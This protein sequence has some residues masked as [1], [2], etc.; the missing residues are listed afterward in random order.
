[1]AKASF[2]RIS[3]LF[4]GF[5]LLLATYSWIF[6]PDSG[7]LYNTRVRKTLGSDPKA[8]VD[9]SCEKPHHPLDPLTVQ[10]IKR[11]RTILSGHDPGFG[12]GSA[13]IHSMALDEPDKTRVVQWK[14]GNRL[15][16]RRAEVVAY[17]EAQT[18]VLTV[19]LDSGR[20][21][22]DV[23]NPTSGY[24][25]LTIDDVFAASQVPMIF[26]TNFLV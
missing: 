22:S 20:I 23:V 16:S 24:P 15:P 9:H 19:D 25:I 6:G 12:S 7:F 21:V 11:V 13:T 2:G 26:S 18:H 3:L 14:K 10:E 4:F 17:W 1:M 8:H 5:L